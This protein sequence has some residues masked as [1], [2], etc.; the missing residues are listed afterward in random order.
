MTACAMWTAGGGGGSSARLRKE[1]RSGLPCISTFPFLL[2]VGRELHLCNINI[3]VTLF[4]WT[5][6]LVE[7]LKQLICCTKKILFSG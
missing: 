6:K 1:L 3:K 7:K 2:W 4:G 5:Y